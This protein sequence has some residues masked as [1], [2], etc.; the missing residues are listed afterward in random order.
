MNKT[1]LAA[2]SL[3]NWWKIPA[4]S[5]A[6]A[7][8]LLVLASCGLSSPVV[9]PESTSAQQSG[10]TTQVDSNSATDGSNGVTM[11]LGTGAG[12]VPV[13]AAAVAGETA[14][15]SSETSSES[16]QV[17]S[18]NTSS[19]PADDVSCTAPGLSMQQTTLALINEAR[20]IARQCGAEAYAVAEPLAWNAQLLLAAERQ[21]T[22][23]AVHNFFSHSGSDGSDVS[24]R[25][26]E[27]GYAW[28]TVGENIA[29]GQKTAQRVIAGWLNS[30]G[31]CRNLMEP[32]FTDVAVSCVEHSQS[33]YGDYWTNVL[34]APR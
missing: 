3:P 31:H 9:P 21:S 20:S 26:T 1:L 14:S 32:A 16:T 19:N 27:A 25:T 11:G 30:P 34:A 10:V 29:A 4:L 13:T 24:T 8:S 28:T 23:M 2:L 5:P 33:D 18:A 17:N 15:A 22:D 6:L 12:A 7:A